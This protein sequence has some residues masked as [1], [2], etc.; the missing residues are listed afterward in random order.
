MRQKCREAVSYET[1][2][3]EMLKMVIHESAINQLIHCSIISSTTTI[4]KNYTF[5][6]PFGK[7][8]T[9]WKKN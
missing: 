8:F 5:K 4:K 7:T 3:I 1:L 6:K 2:D 9:M